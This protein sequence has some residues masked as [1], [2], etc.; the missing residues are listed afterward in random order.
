M[1][2]PIITHIREPRE[3][4]VGGETFLAAETMI[5]DYGPKSGKTI[6]YIRAQ[7]STSE[8]VRENRAMLNR[9]LAGQGCRLKEDNQ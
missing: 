3:V 7:T 5:M 8:E 2:Y 9:F 4:T 1:E 6:S